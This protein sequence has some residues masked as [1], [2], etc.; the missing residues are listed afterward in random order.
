MAEALQRIPGISLETDSGEGRFINIRGLDS[1]LNATHL[2]RGASAGLQSILALRRRPRGRVRYLSHRDRR[3]R[4]G[5]QDTAAG[6]GRRRARRLDQ[7]LAA[8]RG[9]A[10]RQAVSSMRTSASGYEPLR[11]DAGVSRRAQH[12]TSF[13]GGDGIGG[14]FAGANAFSVVITGVYHEDKRGVDDLEESYSDNQS[15][16]VPDKVLSNL[17][18]RRYEYHR[19]NATARR[20]TSMPRPTE[21]HLAVPARAVVRVSGGRPQALPGAQQPR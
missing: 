8:H 19:A 5:H 9:R 18:Y 11:D 21:A 15:N 3:R 7:P 13:S 2:R 17:Q 4:R 20:P 16:G 12:R 10:R 14:L 6:H 1:D